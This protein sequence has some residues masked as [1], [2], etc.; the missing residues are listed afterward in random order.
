VNKY[1]FLLLMSLNVQAGT[2]KTD[3][4]V[5]LEYKTKT[6]FTETLTL[7]RKS[8]R[9]ILNGF[10]MPSE[11]ILRGKKILSFLVMNNTKVEP[12]LKCY[13][14]H[15]T[16]T[17]KRE[18]VNKRELGCLGSERFGKLISAFRSL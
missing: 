1:L 14:G 16:F 9:M 10:F 2:V 7:E 3:F 4:K 6:N 12:K 18:K 8:K 17:I 13:A 11:K 5:Q 15:Y